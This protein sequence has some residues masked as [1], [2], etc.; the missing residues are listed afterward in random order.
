LHTLA[1]LQ[2]HAASESAGWV[3]GTLAAFTLGGSVGLVLLKWLLRKVTS[4]TLLVGSTLGCAASYGL[5]LGAGH[6][7][8]APLA[9]LLTG[10]F[11]AAHY[12]LTSA[13]AYAAL[14]GR[15]TLVAAAGQ[16]FVLFELALPVLLGVVADEL[17]LLVALALLL[18]QPLGILLAVVAAPRGD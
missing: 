14:P 15:S 8:W 17:G 16:C 7:W 6:C 10:F 12:P 5:W 13:R 11:A 1:G 18:A 2:V 4:R 9:L 3:A